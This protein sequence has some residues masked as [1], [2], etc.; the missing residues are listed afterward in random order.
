VLSS[1]CEDFGGAIFGHRLPTVP[2]PAVFQF[3]RRPPA[4]HTPRKKQQQLQ[5]SPQESRRPRLLRGAR[6]DG[7]ARLKSPLTVSDSKDLSCF[8]MAVRHETPTRTSQPGATLFTLCGPSL[9]ETAAAV[10]RTPCRW[11]QVLCSCPR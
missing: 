3:R 2:N 9:G 8:G 6:Q 11:A 7:A 5:G 4:L 10:L 1:G